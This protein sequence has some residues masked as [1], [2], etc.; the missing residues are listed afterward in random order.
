MCG[1]Y[2]LTAKE[3]HLREHFG[4]DE[5]PEWKPCWNIALTQQLATV[6]QHPAEP[7]RIFGRMRWGA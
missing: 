2:R 5:D 1:R 3:R 4:F 7:V 6:R